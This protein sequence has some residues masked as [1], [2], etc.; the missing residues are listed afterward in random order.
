MSTIRS[1]LRCFMVRSARDVAAQALPNWAQIGVSL[2]QNFYDVFVACPEQEQRALLA[3]AEQVSASEWAS[4]RGQVAGELGER[5]AEAL[6][7]ARAALRQAQTQGSRRGGGRG[8]ALRRGLNQTMAAGMVVERRRVGSGVAR[9]VLMGGGASE[10]PPRSSWPQVPGFELTGW[11]GEGATAKVFVA[12]RAGTGELGAPVALKV[13]PLTDRGRFERE[14]ELMARARSPHLLSAL[15]HG[16]IEGFVPLFW[17]EMP[18]MGGNTL[19]DVGEVGLEEGVKLC[20][21]VLEGLK[22]LHALGVAHRDL[23]PSNVLLTSS[24]EVRLADFGLSKRVGDASASITTTGTV[25]GSPA[26]MSPEAI[27]GERVGLSGDVWS[28]GVLMCEVLAGH[29]PFPGNV[30]GQV[31]AAALRDEPDLSG[32]PKWI[33]GGVKA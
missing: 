11:L 9:S 16:V 14:V 3:A 13:G 22:A 5:Y 12:R 21:G 28:F 19:A 1:K 2:A 4:I 26:Y 33:Q 6:D 8:E 18:L 10:P 20:L 32:L 7:Q 25:V 27:N 23:K 30:A 17:I 29:L 31:W 15:D 24:G